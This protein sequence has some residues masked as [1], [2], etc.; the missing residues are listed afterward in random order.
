VGVRIVDGEKNTDNLGL[1]KDCIVVGL[2]NY[3]TDNV[4]QYHV[5]R[6]M[7]LN[8]KIKASFWD[9]KTYK[10]AVVQTVSGNQLGITI[11]D[12]PGH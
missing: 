7:T 12:Y 3:K 8:P 2:N 5:V 6:K 4:K 1:K 11:A 9:G 10:Q